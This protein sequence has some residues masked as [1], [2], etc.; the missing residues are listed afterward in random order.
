MRDV[1]VVIPARGADQRL[2]HQV[3]AVSHSLLVACTRA[4]VVIVSD[5]SDA[6]ARRAQELATA[7]GLAEIRHVNVNLR[8]AAGARN[9]GAATARSERLLFCDADDVVLPGWATAHLAA[10]TDATITTG[11]TI[12]YGVQSRAR[13]WRAHHPLC[14]PPV[15]LGYQ[16]FAL[17]S[18]VGVYQRLFSALQGFDSTAA[19]WNCEDIDLSWRAQN[20]GAHVAWHHAAKVLWRQP[21]SPFAD[22]RRCLDYSMGH[23]FLSDRY[24]ITIR[25]WPSPYE[26]RRWASTKSLMSGLTRRVGRALGRG[27]F[28][29]YPFSRY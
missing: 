27:R 28:L 10:L 19:E 14:S 22:L 23:V 5:A 16:A 4:E 12:P 8:N 3:A 24:A 7:P 11:P 21:Y 29:F 20:L 2:A 13:P 15:A 26:L 9:I 6:S 18:N 25:Y 1:S 17:S